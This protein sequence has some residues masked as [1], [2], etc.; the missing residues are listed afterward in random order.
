METKISF[1]PTEK[2][3]IA[4]DYLLDN[5]TEELLYGGAA[6][7]GGGK[8]LLGCY[9]IL[10]SAINYPETR[11]LIGRAVLKSLKE[12]TL[13]TLFQ[14]MNKFEMKPDIHF[15]YNAM[16][17]IVKIFN[18]SEIVLKDL[19]EYPSDPEFDS[20][21]STEYTYAFI[22][23]CSQVS[24]KAKEVL[25]TRLRY[26]HNEYKLKPKILYCTNPCKNWAYYEFYKPWN[27]KKLIPRKKFVQAF[28]TDNPY[29]PATYIET[30]RN[31]DKVTKERLLN[32]NWNYDDDPAR[33]MEYDAILDAFTNTFI[34]GNGKK[35]ISTDLAMQGR[36]RFV[37]S[38]WDGMRCK[39]PI[40]KNISNG[41][42]I[43]ETL[44][45]QMLLNSVPQSQ[46]IADSSGMGEYL[47]SYI[48]GIKA[49]HGNEKPTNEEFANA[50]SECYFKLAEMIN[51][52]LIYIECDEKT[53][54]LI[55][56]ELE[57]IKRKDID[58]DDTRKRV[59][60]KEDIKDML[61]RSPDFADT[62]SMRMYF[63]TSI[64]MS[65]HSLSFR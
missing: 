18:G 44:K 3:Q 35:Y 27:E 11:Y 7:A 29:I 14:I 40:V 1:C 65:L 49:F 10:K 30:L 23:E 8:S 54:Q 6:V 42:E 57:Q 12:S 28:V 58:K 16:E 34:K 26:K 53:K 63:E 25:K 64:P 39:F 32:G 20:L 22:D 60:A 55:I 45:N 50:R 56:E 33:L 19:E 62:L 24:M 47:V 48:R 36:D 46:V 13:K 41:K 2:Q 51:K 31:T 21:G 15:K 43:E 61:G 52:R 4:L 38:T 37:V 17:G 5:E 59:I 9:W